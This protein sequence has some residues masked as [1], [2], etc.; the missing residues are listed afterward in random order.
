MAGHDA[1]VSSLSF[2]PVSAVL[3]SSSWDS[4]VRVWDVFESKGHRETLQLTSDC[5]LCIVR[6]SYV[7]LC[8][9]RFSYVK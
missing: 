1:P 8:T 2:S 7:Y 6:Y 9:I 4:T 3:V 5:E